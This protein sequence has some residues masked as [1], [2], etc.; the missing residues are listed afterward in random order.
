MRCHV[1]LKRVRSRWAI[2]IAGHFKVLLLRQGRGAA[3]RHWVNQGLFGAIRTATGSTQG[4]SAGA[5]T[6]RTSSHQDES[7]K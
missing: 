6:M 1:E 3:A 7:S 5:G 4:A 2:Q